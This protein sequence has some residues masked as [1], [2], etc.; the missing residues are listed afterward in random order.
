MENTSSY[1]VPMNGGEGH[2]F[3]VQNK[4]EEI[5]N[6]EFKKILDKK[7]FAWKYE[8]DLTKKIYIQFFTE[9]EE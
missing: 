1:T 4:R 3:N 7:T 2:D 8:P 6:R 5:I 9:G